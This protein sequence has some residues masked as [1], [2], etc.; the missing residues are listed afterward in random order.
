[1]LKKKLLKD[2][3][4]S[5]L[6]KKSLLKI[7]GKINESIE[8]L[9]ECLNNG[10]KILICGNGGSAADAQ[11]LAAEFLIRLRPNVNRKSLPVIPLALDTST[12]TACGNDYHFDK[13]FSRLISSLGKN[14]DVLISI[15]TS[16]KSKNIINALK[17]A[18]KQ[19]IKTISFLG[20]N[21][22]IAKKFSDVSLIVNSNNVARIQESHIFLGHFI[23]QK[24]EENI[25]RIK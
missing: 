8:I 25:I 17:Q 24:V 22:G 9:T 1:M 19:N 12:L 11:H 3:N 5:I 10:N 16:G 21:G 20:Q 4:Q 6:A 2:L 7:S 18:K 14:Y 15:S 23:F 13:I